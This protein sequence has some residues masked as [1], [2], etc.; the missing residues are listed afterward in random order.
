M[1]TLP[2]SP[3]ESPSQLCTRLIFEPFHTS[4]SCLSSLRKYRK[5]V[6]KHANISSRSRDEL[7]CLAI[8][9]LAQNLKI[10]YHCSFPPYLPFSFLP[11]LQL[12]SSIT[13]SSFYSFF[14]HHHYSRDGHV[15]DSAS[16][17]P[18]SLASVRECKQLC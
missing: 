1:G 10:S 6:T 3:K 9:R 14:T 2:S 7:N 16:S 4:N 15:K 12:E 11:H 13:A 18:V 17:S 8:L 5:S